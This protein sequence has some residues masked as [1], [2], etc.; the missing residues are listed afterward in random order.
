MSGKT[1]LSRIRLL[2][3]AGAAKPAPPVGPA[4]GQHGLNIMAFCKEFNAK[5]AEYKPNIPVP[6]QIT[7]YMDKSFTFTMKSPPVSYFVKK[8]A[9]LTSGSQLPGTVLAGEVSLKH[10]F[11]IARI[12]QTDPH[13]DR[14]SL[15]GHCKSIMGT[16]TAMGVKVLNREEMELKLAEQ[17]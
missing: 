15:E 16:C 1:V 6:V 14:I 13:G 4:L 11:E 9:G 10:V 3:P 2:V 17:P 5:T 7:A 12:K 8:A